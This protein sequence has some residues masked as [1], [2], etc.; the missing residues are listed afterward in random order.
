MKSFRP[1]YIMIVMIALTSGGSGQW[2]LETGLSGRYDDNI[3][4]NYLRIKDRIS[5]LSLTGSYTWEPDNSATELFYSGSL[6]YYGSTVARTFHYHTFGLDYSHIYGDDRETRL[7]A[8]ASYS[9][10][11][12]RGDY[13]LYD[14]SQMSAF[15][16]V[17][18]PIAESFTGMT[19][20]SFTYLNMK[21]AP[22]F[23]YVEHA[24]FFQ[25]KSF[26][27]TQTTVILQADL[28][29]KRYTTANI[30]TTQTAGSG[31]WGQSSSSDGSSNPGVTQMI[32]MMRIG[33]ALIEG[34][35]LSLSGQYILNLQSNPRYIT[36]SDGIVSGDDI[37]DDQY[38]YQGPSFNLTLTQLLPA[39]VV[40]KLSGG[41]QN[42]D[43]LVR[44]AYDLAGI[45]IAP[46]RTDERKNIFLSIEKNFDELG[47]SLGLSYEFLENSS[48]DEYFNY[49]NNIF[50]LSLGYQY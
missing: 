21:E 36:S 31:R 13:I 48:N 2:S 4:N 22:D 41:M 8:G 30:D 16:T 14:H 47:L 17:D 29:Y 15:S 9:T 38:S 34:T 10:R 6:N 40:L 27:P 19:G 5:S 1:V 45:E 25:L 26:L 42:R 3:N 24:A 39:Q 12:N 46:Q 11:I 35:G 18:F 20:Y 32:G 28:G 50:G 44:P 23:N 49:N 43:Y 37:F 7:N 33:Q